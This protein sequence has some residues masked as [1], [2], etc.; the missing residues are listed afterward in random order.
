[1]K[2]LLN[3]AA[4]FLF[5]SCKNVQVK[6]P[7]FSDSTSLPQTKV[8]SNDSLSN[9]QIIKVEQVSASRLLIPGKS[10]GLTTLNEKATLVNKRLGKADEGDAAMGKALLTWFS[11]PSANAK[12]STKYSTTIYFVTNMGGPNEASRVKQIRITSP[13]FMT[14]NRIGVTSILDSVLHYFPSAKKT[15]LYNAADKTPVYIYDDVATGITF[16]IN[17]KNKCVGITIHEPNQKAFETYIAFLNGLK[18]L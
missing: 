11:K 2:H 3:I 9:E 12:D 6:T 1:M 14:L 16:E 17:S 15:A 4:I 10:I 8:I 7:E 5:T 13:F 18:M